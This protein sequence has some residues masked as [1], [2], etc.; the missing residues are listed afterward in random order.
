MTAIQIDP[1]GC[2]CTECLTGL[3]VP[4]DRATDEQVRALLTGAMP[5]A[6]GE[7][8]TLTTVAEHYLSDVPGPVTYHMTL[9]ATYSGRT[10]EWEV[11]E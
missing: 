10:W 5:N 7:D 4:L 6:T 3:Y 1:P 11:I 9:A 8:F 2:G